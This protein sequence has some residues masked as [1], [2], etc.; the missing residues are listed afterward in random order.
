MKLLKITALVLA[1]GLICSGCGK[2]INASSEE[3]M[4]SSIETLQ[5]S[6]SQEE[7]KEF[8]ACCAVVVLANLHKG[9]DAYKV[10]DGKSPEEVKWMAQ[11]I[12]EKRQAEE[13]MRKAER[14]QKD[15]A[16]LRER[17]AELDKVIK[18]NDENRT[19]LRKIIITGATFKKVK[20]RFSE[21]PSISFSINNSSEKTI[22]RIICK[23]VLT[24]T[25][26]SV[27]WLED[28]FGY[29]FRGGLNA[30][31][32]QHL[33]LRPNPFGDWGELDNRDDYTLSLTL[34][35]IENEKK[36]PLWIIEDGAEKEKAECEQKL[37]ALLKE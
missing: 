9:E 26:R 8:T 30:G 35:G 33:D 19:Q 10:L 23:A 31:E 22:S 15:I 34:I 29:S 2:K 6:M 20:N 21:D 16:E 36:D 17:I 25:G 1:T 4:K 13:K 24:S 27:P 28:G 12:K 37:E 7:A 3:K 14:K 5:K 32:K 18:Q 11:T